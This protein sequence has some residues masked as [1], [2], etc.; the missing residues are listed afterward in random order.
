VASPTSQVG[1]H[2]FSYWLARPFL[3]SLSS[4]ILLSTFNCGAVCSLE[5]PRIFF[6][7]PAPMPSSPSFSSVFQSALFALF[8]T[9]M[10]AI[11]RNLLRTVGKSFV[12]L[13]LDRNPFLMP[14]R[15]PPRFFFFFYSCADPVS[16]TPFSF[17]IFDDVFLDHTPR[18]LLRPPF[19]HFPCDFSFVL[20]QHRVFHTLDFLHNRPRHSLWRRWRFFPISLVHLPFPE[21]LCDGRFIIPPTLNCCLHRK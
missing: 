16:W 6:S 4:L 15:F 7:L 13:L 8:D 10:L 18:R 21:N 2:S 9:P 19:F 5:S 20:P 3:C 11:L 14:C 17:R 12:C 1:P